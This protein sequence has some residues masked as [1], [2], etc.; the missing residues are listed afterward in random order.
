MR[1]QI[2]WLVTGLLAIPILWGGWKVY[3]SVR[4]NARREQS[5]QNLKQI[6]SALHAYHDNYHCFPPAY[7]L[8]A[9]EKP[10]HSWRVLLLPYLGEQQLYDHY[11]FDE[12][13]DGPHNREL[14]SLR[15]KAYASPLQFSSDH[16]ITTYLAVVSRRTMW[17]AYF[18]V[19]IEQVSDG[20]SNTIQ[21][22]ENDASETPWTEPRDMR[23]RE[24]LRLLKPGVVSAH[25]SSGKIAALFS[26]GHARI[27]SDRINRDFFISLLT[28]AYRQVM[29]PDD[30]WPPGLLADDRSPAA[31]NLPSPV[32]VGQ[33]PATRVLSVPDLPLKA[34]QSVLYC[35]T[36]QLAWDQL[37]P[38]TSSP[39]VVSSP[40]EISEFLNAHPFPL[41]ALSKD[42]YFVGVSGLEAENSK[43]LFD[44]FRTRFPDAPAEMLKPIPDVDDFGK[45][46]RIL[47]HLQKSMP[48]SD[49]LERIPEPLKFPDQPG[50]KFVQSFGWPSAQDEGARLPVLQQTVAV[51]DYVSDEDF[52]LLLRTDGP[53]RDEI[54]L[55]KVAPQNSLQA[56]WENVADRLQT[57]LAKQVETELRAHDQLQIPIMSFGVLVQFPELS[58][59]IPT[60]ASPDRFISLALQTIQFRL[61][62][63]G[64]ELIS[65]AQMIVGENG[66]GPSLDID[67][68]KPRHLVFDRPFMLALRENKSEAPYFL[69]WIGNAD[70]MEPAK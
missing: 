59:K 55:A 45:A 24:A 28:P 52:V 15:P 19:S 2:R 54:I 70:L 56:T 33:F 36:I 18:P 9:D 38:E 51:R 31:A 42:A 60:N 43:G 53:Q 21:L 66:H 10:W 4:L 40:T 5:R 61:D 12:P 22:V 35:A 16:K 11:R 39:V 48:F 17:P 14:Q 6:G 47:V 25:A 49:V 8:G 32:D 46:V 7:V 57:P 69:A 44:A 68:E 13:W 29:V 67:P 50:G 1:R 34:D 3:S 26:D 27:I 64:A 23:E 63:H 65:D 58:V 30:R 41:T 20:I 62:E 37:R